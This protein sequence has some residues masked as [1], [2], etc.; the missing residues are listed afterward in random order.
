MLVPSTG[1]ISSIFTSADCVHGHT[2]NTEWKTTKFSIYPLL[3]STK[4]SACLS[5]SAS[6]SALIV[7]CPSL[8]YLLNGM[9]LLW[10]NPLLKCTVLPKLLYI[11]Y[12]YNLPTQ[13]RGQTWILNLA[14]L[15]SYHIFAQHFLNFCVTVTVA[16]M[17]LQKLMGTAL[18]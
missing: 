7:C 2:L 8:F 16:I 13:I 5:A 4:N 12:R 10:N 6:A 14:V 15:L 18:F 11:L 9:Q 3:F 17:I 1:L